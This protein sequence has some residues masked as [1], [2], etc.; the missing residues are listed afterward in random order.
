MINFCKN[1]IKRLDNT[2]SKTL[3]KMANSNNFDMNILIVIQ[4]VINVLYRPEFIF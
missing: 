4:I 2:V 3:Y 1:N